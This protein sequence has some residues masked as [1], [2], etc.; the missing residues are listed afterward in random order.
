MARTA[1]PEPWQVPLSSLK[2][3]RYVEPAF[4]RRPRG[5][6]PAGWVELSFVVGTDGR[7]RKVK[8]IS[9]SPSDRYESAA[10]A[11]V[12]RWRFVPA[13]E[14]GRPVERRTAVRLRFL[15]K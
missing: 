2:F 9:A 1:P 4:R 8:V 12:K 15:P 14:A 7:T 6:E 3:T 13:M 5:G 11:A 10:L